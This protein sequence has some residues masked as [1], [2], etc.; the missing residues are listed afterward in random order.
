MDLPTFATHQPYPESGPLR[1]NLDVPLVN[2]R[3]RLS[4]HAND[5]VYVYVMTSVKTRNGGFLQLGCGPNF[6]GGEITICSCMAQMRTFEDVQPG[7]WVSG[8]TGVHPISKGNELFYLTRIR[9]SAISQYDLWNKLPQEVRKAKAAHL[10]PY[11]DVFEPTETLENLGD[12][13]AYNSAN[14]KPPIEG[15]VHATERHPN[16]WHLDIDYV[17]KQTGR[18]QAFLVGDPSM[19]FIWTRPLIYFDGS[20]LKRHPRSK[21]RDIREFLQV[22]AALPSSDELDA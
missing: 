19:T 20:T 6:Q 16:R 21:K 7:V 8:L 11:G 13:A 22:L 9:D 14:Y 3:D 2:L 4:A 12:L 18:R 17:G 15:H 10:S 1:E 5:T